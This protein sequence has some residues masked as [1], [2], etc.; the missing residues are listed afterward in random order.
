MN[1]TEERQVKEGMAKT[2]APDLNISDQEC[3]TTG[4]LD[5]CIIVILGASGDLTARKL[6][7]A[8]FNLYLNGGLPDRFVIVG[9][10]RTEV[11]DRAF[12]DKMKEFLSQGENF[13]ESEWTAFT[14]QMHYQPIDNYDRLAAFEELNDFLGE[15]DR[16]SGTKGNRLFYL[17]IPPSLYK[18]VTHMIGQSGMSSTTEG[19]SRIVVEK[20]FGRDLRTA[21]D[22]DRA[23][24]EYFEEQ[25]IFRIDHY[26][27]KETVQNIL[28]F[29]YANS[30][31]E[32][33]WNRRYVSHIHITASETVGVERR[34]GYYEK[35][36][37][38]RDMFQN[39]MMQL[40]ALTAMEPPPLFEAEQVR[41]E[42]TKVFRALRP[43][44]VENLRDYIVLGQYGRGK[45][46]DKEVTSYR[47]EEGVKE[48]SLIPTFASMKVFIDN[49][50]W[51]GVPFYLTSG[52]RLTR[53]LTEIVIHF[54]EVPHCVFR[55][56]IHEHIPP[57]QMTLGVY[58][59]EK[60]T[61]TFQAKN[62]G[63]TIRLRPVTMDFLYNQNY[64][65]PI[66]EAYE[67]VLIDCIRGDQ[68]LFWR[69]DA[70]EL[71]WAFL[72]PILEECETCGYREEMLQSYE[73][74]SWGPQSFLQVP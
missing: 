36:G 13:D 21:V 29:R 23:I 27:A 59:E 28:M 30:I 32:P 57:N 69:E 43:F 37:V 70:V 17:A 19:W 25:Q 6:I 5:P 47:E 33:I 8:L 61:L 10:A 22:L 15:L 14:K 51:Q 12:A 4:K 9:S 44:P 67:K 63:A 58:P 3:V 39:H 24:H 46:N 49:W 74:G 31:F 50:R 64:R 65:G 52:K 26:L 34:A 56:S 55:N 45:I 60:I 72:T 71:C 68:M 35:S 73:A 41:D 7:P 66:L 54:R 11:S 42:K 62:P 2:A 16:K 48:N 1:E 38:L 20:P 40:L 18:T 53:K